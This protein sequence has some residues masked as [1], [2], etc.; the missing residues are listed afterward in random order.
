M[1]NRDPDRH[2]EATSWRLS[3]RACLMR[4]D[5]LR[6]LGAPD[7][8]FETLAGAGLELG[9]RIIRHGA[10]P[11]HIP[12]LVKG[13]IK[14]EA[15]EIPLEDQLRFIKLGFDRRWL[16]WACFR[17][18]LQGYSHPGSLWRAWQ[19]VEKETQPQ[20]YQPYPHV[21]E[22][23]QHSIQSAKVS[24]LI[25]T[26]RRYP[27]LRV[28]LSHLRVQTH[29]PYEV[30][31][32][33]Q[34]PP[35]Q[36]EPNLSAEFPD[37]PLHWFTLDQPGQC[38]SRNFGL[39]KA[40]GN[41]ILF[42]DDDDEVPPDLIEKHLATLYALQINVSSGV[43]NEVGAGPLPENFRWMRVSSVFPTNNTMI[44]KGVLHTSGLFDLA[45]DHG[46]RA[47]HDLGMRIY[48]S[49]ELMVLNPDINVLHHHAPQGGLR[50]HKARVDTYAASR[51][52]LFKFI[53][54]TV[55]DIYLAKRYFTEDQVRERVW[56]SLLGTFSI[57]GAWWKRI[58]KIL[59]AALFLPFN[60]LQIRRRTRAAEALLENYPQIPNLDEDLSP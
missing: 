5:V 20:K 54:P 32:I 14:A 37:L 39:Q 2:I 25:P 26:L 34:T 17:N 24:V 38:T 35:D 45:Y 58:L 11:H 49:G 19:T 15:V 56:I 46:Q 10:F 30:L 13:E 1:L 3:L 6:H 8:N 7:P 29:P 23:N 9:F 36:Q 57:Q 59:I 52:R 43:A 60:L 40:G 18:L 28:L 22:T 42:I 33:D 44:R 48:L 27:Y 16:L 31:V 21:I 4:T 53:L 51:K 55:S 41:F 50:E 12:E 47:D